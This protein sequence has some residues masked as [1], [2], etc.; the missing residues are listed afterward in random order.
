MVTVS[1]NIRVEEN[2]EGIGC[3]RDISV[4]IIEHMCYILPWECRMTNRER[5]VPVNIMRPSTICV[6]TK[7]EPARL[8]VKNLYVRIPVKGTSPALAYSGGK[9]F[10]NGTTAAPEDP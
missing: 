2:Y 8:N 6:H 1:F 9:S 10:A 3:P 4:D 7:G 5:K